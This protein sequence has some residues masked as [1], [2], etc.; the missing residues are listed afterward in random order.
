MSG[1]WEDRFGGPWPSGRSIEPPDEQPEPAEETGDEPTGDEVATPWTTEDSSTANQEG[2]D[3]FECLGSE[4][5]PLQLCKIDDPALWKEERGVE[6]L[7]QW[8]QDT[9]LWE[10]VWES[11]RQGDEPHAKALA[12]LREE[13]AQEYQ[14]IER[15]I[16]HRG[17]G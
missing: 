3:L 7:A 12:V 9:D 13:N 16:N 8:E 5:G 11:A 2:W 10:Y 14:A 17:R 1:D 4:N 15:W 6:V